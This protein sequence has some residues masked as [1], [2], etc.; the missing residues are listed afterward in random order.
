MKV[1]DYLVSQVRLKD[2]KVQQLY[3]HE[4]TRLDGAN[5]TWSS[6]GQWFTETEL[7]KAI[8]SRSVWTHEWDYVNR[9]WKFGESVIIVNRPPQSPYLKTAPDDTLQNN[10]LHLIQYGE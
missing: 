7:I 6:P 10:L 3:V 1:G 8:A 2:G 9:R 4:V 5:A